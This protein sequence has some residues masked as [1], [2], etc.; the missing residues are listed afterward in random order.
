LDQLP[1]T[2]ASSVKTAGWRGTMRAL[3]AQG[4]LL[5]TN[6]NQ[7]EAVILSTA[8]YTRLMAAAAVT[9]Q[10]VPDPL[11][12]LR[13]QFDER[14]AVLNEDSAGDRLRAVMDQPGKLNGSVKAGS[15]Y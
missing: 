7:P 10:V 1:I 13:R 12:E 6:H 15:T 9:E 14:L 4:K 3:S 2:T 8:E 5:V 11:V